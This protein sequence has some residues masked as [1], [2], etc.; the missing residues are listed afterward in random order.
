MEILQCSEMLN[1]KSIITPITTNL[2]TNDSSLA[3]YSEPKLYCCLAGSLQYLML[4]KHDIAY[5]VNKLYQ[6]M[7]QPQ[8]VHF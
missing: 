4:T 2:S 1:Y 8:V 7:H 5:S 6:H 3:D